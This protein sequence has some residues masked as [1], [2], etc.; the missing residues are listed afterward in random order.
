MT[1]PDWGCGKTFDASLESAPRMSCEIEARY[2]G[3]ALEK[4]MLQHSYSI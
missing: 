3:R 4:E 1:S 2:V